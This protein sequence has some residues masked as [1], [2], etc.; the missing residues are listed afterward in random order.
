MQ[1]KNALLISVHFMFLGKFM[2]EI[3]Q[4]YKRF[5]TVKKSRNS[6]VTV[7]KNILKLVSAALYA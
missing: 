3:R 7:S 2:F 4:L 6:N 5:P 1:E